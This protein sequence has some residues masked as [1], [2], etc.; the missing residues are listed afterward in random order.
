M[1]MHLPSLL[2]LY[3]PPSALP[4]RPLEAA[5]QVFAADTDGV[6]PMSPALPTPPKAEI[7]VPYVP[8]HM[9]DDIHFVSDHM[10]DFPRGGGLGESV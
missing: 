2:P 3:S 9:A 6:V 8:E 1:P 5:D 4:P 7:G 10:S